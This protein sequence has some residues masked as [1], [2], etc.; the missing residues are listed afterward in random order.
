VATEDGRGAGPAADRGRT[1]EF[2]N[3]TAV[4][5]AGLLK[6]PFGDRR[7]YPLSL[8]RFPLDDGLAAEQVAGDVKLTR[9]RDA[10]IAHVRAAGTVALE[11]ARCLRPFEQT[12]AVDFDE[13]YRQTVDV[14][15]GVGLEPGDD[16]E[17]ETAHID[18]N[19]ELDLA[20]VLRQE[21]LVVLPM[22]P[23]CGE[24]CP[25]PEALGGAAATA[26]ADPVDDRFAALADLLNDENRPPTNT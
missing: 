12:F 7:T 18:E 16:E 21:I 19:H 4:N 5:V 15:T 17:E 14:R 3:D 24:S 23:D 8:E 9:L 1:I 6:A 10:V 20:D 11:C 26:L 25:G 22:R 13:E 2:R